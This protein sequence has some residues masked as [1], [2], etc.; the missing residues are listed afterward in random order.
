MTDPDFIIGGAMRAGTT[1]LAEAL[2]EHPDISMTTPKEPSFFAVGSGALTFAGP[3]D[4]WFAGQHARD[5]HSYQ[6]LFAGPGGAVSG[7]A[8]AMYLTLPGVAAAIEERRPDVKLVFVLRDPVARAHSAWLYL[9]AHGREELDDFA[10]ALDAE[11]GRRQSGYGPMWWYVAASR[12]DEGL[13]EFYACFPSSSIFVTTTEGLRAD[14]QGTMSELWRFLGV[15][16]A[17]LPQALGRAVNAAGAPRA[18]WLVRLLYPAD[19]VRRTASAVAPPV[20]RRLVRRSRAAAVRPPAPMPAQCR[21]RLVEQLHD[22]PRQVAELT[23]IDTTAWPTA[24]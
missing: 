2:A 15:A 11:G 14:P 12:Y 5:W 18:D 24:R 7:E 20:V 13:R 17:T 4:Q 6:R 8:S 1:A 3:G 10:E 16:P 21:A 22:V 19:R 9:R 23:G